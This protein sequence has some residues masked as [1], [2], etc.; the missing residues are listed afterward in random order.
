MWHRGG[1]HRPLSW[2]GLHHQPAADRLHP[3]GHFLES[4]G[5][6]LGG[7][8]IWKSAAVVAHGQGDLGI[9]LTQADLHSRRPRALLSPVESRLGHPEK[10][11]VG[12][13]HLDFASPPQLGEGGNAGCRP[14]VVRE[15]IECGP[16]SDVVEQRRPELAG[17]APELLADLG[18]QD[19]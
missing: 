11:Q 1:H 6:S 8:T 5:P 3:V 18:G 9:I 2:T 14:E 13:G 19:P 15:L 10:H 16:K 4:S 17:H 7:W 12:A